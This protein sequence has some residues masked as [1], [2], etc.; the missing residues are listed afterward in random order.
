M[1]EL[2]LTDEILM[3]FADGELDEPVAAAVA[4][5]MA[6]DPAIARKIVEFQRSRRLTRSFFASNL[7]PDV[8]SEL[9]AAISAQIEA[10]E[11]TSQSG[12]RPTPIE[13]RNLRP[14]RPYPMRM[15]LAAS[16]AAVAVA[17]GYLIG[18]QSQPEAGRLAQLEDPLVRQE[19]SR[20]GSGREVELP[21]GRL[22]VVSTYRLA[23]ESLCREFRLHS[24]SSAT[25]AV[26]CRSDE[27]NVTF[28]LATPV[29]E[30]EYMP[31]SGGDLVD[32]Y[33]GNLGAGSPLEGEAEAK[34]LA[35]FVR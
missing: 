5:V 13:T 31:S 33:L 12:D 26:A 11:A 29:K 23:N 20:L 3:A 21:I 7:A 19:L 28:A 4:R 14:S 18:Q 8:P 35:E 10:Y 32:A 16:F 17:A 1:S 9:H 6:Q 22:R 2:H 30:A 24:T 15:A 27:W 25:N 34:A